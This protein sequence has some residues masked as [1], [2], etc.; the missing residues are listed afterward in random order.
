[1]QWIKSSKCEQ[2]ACVEVAWGEGPEEVIGVRNS[3]IPGETVWFTRD[4]WVAF[5]AGAHEGEFD[6]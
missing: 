3:A 4:E 1:M 6:L 2:G 5:I